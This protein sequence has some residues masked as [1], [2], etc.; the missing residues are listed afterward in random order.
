[1]QQQNVSKVRGI[2]KRDLRA[3]R[4]KPVTDGELLHTQML[5]I[6]QIPL[7]ES[8]VDKIAHGLIERREGGFPLD[9]P[10]RVA[11]SY[12]K[13]TARLVWEAFAR[14]IRPNDLVQVT[15]GPEPE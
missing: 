7:S 11:R 2:V 9:E 15:G 10:A 6:R 3:R 5:L 13:I 14:W 4:E 12:R 8:G 1:V